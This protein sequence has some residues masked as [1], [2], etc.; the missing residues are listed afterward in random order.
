MQFF[1]THMNTTLPRP[2]D[3]PMVLRHKV[4]S[5][6]EARIAGI[7]PDAVWLADE[8]RAVAVRRLGNIMRRQ[9]RP[10]WLGDDSPAALAGEDARLDGLI[11]QVSNRFHTR[12]PFLGLE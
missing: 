11:K 1:L 6:G 5:L 2:H 10:D 9:E 12:F 7:E 3:R 4:P 8:E